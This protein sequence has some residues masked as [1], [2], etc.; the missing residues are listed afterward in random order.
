MNIKF[1][2][3]KTARNKHI[4]LTTLNTQ[5]VDLMNPDLVISYTNLLDSY[6]RLYQ[7]CIRGVTTMNSIYSMAPALKNASKNPEEFAIV[8]SDIQK[9]LKLLPNLQELEEKLNETSKILNVNIAKVNAAINL[10]MKEEIKFSGLKLKDLY[11]QC[12]ILESQFKNENEKN[13]L[14]LRSK[15]SNETKDQFYEKCLFDFKR[16]LIHAKNQLR[17]YQLEHSDV[18][19]EFKLLG[20]GIPIIYKNDTTNMQ[21]HWK[22]ICEDIEKKY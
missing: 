20:V 22:N 12:E 19:R 6:I 16:K 4:E 13:I 9:R 8:L 18:D 3:F 1:F 2:S 14:Y 7:G 21:Q 11:S 5:M 10:D 15:N 17:K